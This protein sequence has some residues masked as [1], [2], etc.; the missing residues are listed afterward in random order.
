MERVR[1]AVQHYAWGDTEFIPDLLGLEP[2]GQPW[3]E[4]WLG[5]HPNGPGRF[6]DGSLLSERVGEL[7]YLLK[8]LAA[9]EP[10]SLQTHPDA[11]RARVGFERGVY[12]DANAK[13]ELLCALT[14]F[15]AL[16]GIRDVD[17]TLG[18][19][20]EIGANGA[21]TAALRADGPAGTLDALYRGSIDPM[22]AIEA[23]IRTTSDR[24]EAAW[25]RRLAARYP[26]EASIAVTLM[27][28]YVTLQPGEC[29][30]LDAGNLHAYLGGA[31]IELMGNSDN[32]VRGGLT[33]KHV[34]VDELLAVVDPTPLSDPVLPRSDRYDLPPAGIS[35]VR[36]E[37]GRSHVATGHELTVDLDGV[38]WYLAPG[39]E[40]RVTTP[41]YA[42][43]PLEC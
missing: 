31:G 38:S 10:L 29:L 17:E 40:L 11:A 33:M 19:L 36:I 4:L 6:D 34:D 12:P 20:A 5:T 25:V 27:L 32:V 37:S 43:V 14:R 26:G 42:V 21:L 2:D 22:P 7:P 35:L 28:N 8:V 13:P 23:C 18:L 16:C 24:A 1:G 41:T 39:D 30:R 9:A 15:E 3:A